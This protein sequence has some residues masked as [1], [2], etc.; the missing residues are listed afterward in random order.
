LYNSADVLWE[1]QCPSFCDPVPDSLLTTSH[2]RAHLSPEEILFLSKLQPIPDAK[3]EFSPSSKSNS[4]PKSSPEVILDASPYLE[5]VQDM[6]NICPADNMI[7]KVGDPRPGKKEVA[8]RP[9][10]NFSLLREKFESQQTVANIEVDPKTS[11]ESP[12]SCAD[13]LAAIHDDSRLNI[14]CESEREPIVCFNK[15]NMTSVVPSRIKQW[16][17]YLKAQNSCNSR[18]GPEPCKVICLPSSHDID[19]GK[20]MK[21]S[22][23]ERRSMFLRQVLSPSWGKKSSLSSGTKVVPAT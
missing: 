10:R 4:S 12:Q 9:H 1:V 23:R 13:C 5:S 21:P 17:N 18:L 19:L 16:N 8:N 22:L 11:S 20:L 2:S 6:D 7:D 3:L 15:E 14:L